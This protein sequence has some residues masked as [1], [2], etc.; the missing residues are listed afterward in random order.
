MCL[1]QS[2][3]VYWIRFCFEWGHSCVRFFEGKMVVFT[4]YRRRDFCVG[5]RVPHLVAAGSAGV[6][7]CRWRRR[8]SPP[9]TRPRLRGSSFRWTV[10]VPLLRHCPPATNWTCPVL[11]L[12]P[13]VSLPSRFH[14][15]HSFL[16]NT[17]AREPPEQNTRSFRPSRNRTALPFRRRISGFSK[18]YTL[19]SNGCL[20]LHT[21]LV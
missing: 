20:F 7:S 11:R 19:F 16:R 13:L 1:R 21:T 12:A 8:P 2:S 10:K 6:S 15:R 18:I 9:L 5:S 4:R 14:A 3:F 17:A